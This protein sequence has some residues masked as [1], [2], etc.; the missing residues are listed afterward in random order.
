MAKKSHGRQRGAPTPR[1]VAGGLFELLGQFLVFHS[2]FEQLLL[3]VRIVEG[4]GSGPH[5]FGARSRVPREF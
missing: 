3:G 5:F 4:I 2:D 1:L